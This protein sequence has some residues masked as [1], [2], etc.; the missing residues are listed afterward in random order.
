MS[1]IKKV[2][3]LTYKDFNTQDEMEKFQLENQEIEAINVVIFKEDRWMTPSDFKP[4]FEGHHYQ[5]RKEVTVVRLIYKK[6]L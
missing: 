1:E 3:V 5:E 4:N 6:Y 2:R